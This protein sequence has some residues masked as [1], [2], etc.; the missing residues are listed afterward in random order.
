M[1]PRQLCSNLLHKFAV[2]PGFCESPHVLEISPRK[3]SHLREGTPEVE[4]KPVD[5]LGTP[6]LALLTGQDVPADSPVE[7]YKLT[8]NRKSRAKPGLGDAPL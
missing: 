5:N 4:G 3:A 1:A 2:G 7:K 6:T 8:V